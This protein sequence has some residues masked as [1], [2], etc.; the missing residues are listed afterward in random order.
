MFGLTTLGTFH[1]AISLIALIAGFIALASHKEISTR[2]TPGKVFVAGTVISC[3][4]G[5]GIFQHGGFGN[6]H[7][8]AIVTL[9]VLGVA[10]AAEYR[11]A[12]GRASRYVE[13]VGYSLALF[14]HFIPGTVETLLR[15]PAGAPYLAHP[16]D[17][18][19]QPIV[20]VFFLVFLVGAALQV[21]RLRRE[22]LISRTRPGTSAPGRAGG[23]R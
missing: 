9:V 20:G 11:V 13:T 10:L 5:F 6:P 14:F 3:L 17:P 19:A 4:T 18:K 12:F 16:D 15:L 23:I 21:V 1:T 22:S 8:L 2:S 7:I